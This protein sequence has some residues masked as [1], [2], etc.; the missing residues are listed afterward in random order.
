MST[1]DGLQL[2]LFVTALAL[3][4]KPMG[5]YLGEVLNPDGRTW[6]DPVMKPFER[7]I[8]RGLGVDPRQEQDWRHYTVA[9]LWFSV[10]S[11]AFTYAILRLQPWLPLN[12]QG[13]GPLSQIGRAHV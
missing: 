1:S 6:F 12:P 2:V 4:T 3:I 7:W 10:I 5:L 8:Y 13:F 9:I 11:C